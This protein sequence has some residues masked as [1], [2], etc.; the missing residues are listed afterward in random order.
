MLLLLIA[1]VAVSF[2]FYVQGA[3]LEEKDKKI[4][5]QA[6]DSLLTALDYKDSIILYLRDSAHS[7]PPAGGALQGTVYI[8]QPIVIHSDGT[9]PVIVTIKDTQVVLASPQP[10]VAVDNFSSI[11][12][13]SNLQKNKSNYNRNLKTDLTNLCL[14]PISKSISDTTK[15]MLLELVRK[16][17][18]SISQGKTSLTSEIERS[19]L[20]ST[21]GATK[22]LSQVNYKPI[23]RTDNYLDDL[24]DNLISSLTSTS[25]NSLSNI[26][27]GLQN[28][29]LWNQNQT[30]YFRIY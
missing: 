19:R 12:D 9:P 5:S 20:N 23:L 11:Y 30:E 27:I 6:K 17:N 15:A 16:I 21:I 28:I 29:C 7:A 13:T 4:A 3:K 10:P 22:T 18:N 1:S 25:R 2:I 14:S 26:R 8:P 24:I